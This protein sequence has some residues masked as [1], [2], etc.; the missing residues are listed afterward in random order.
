MSEEFAEWKPAISGKRP[1]KSGHRCHDTERADKPDCGD[2]TLHGSGCSGGPGRLVEDL[3]N[4]VARGCLQ[5]CLV[6]SDAEQEDK[7][8]GEC[9]RAV[10]GD[11]LNQHPRNHD[12]CV[13]Y[14]FAHM[15]SS[16]EA[17]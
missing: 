17:W 3:N 5:R 8:E 15:D 1:G 9:Q 4:G 13:P 10:N 14:L 12:G 16:I 2:R 7:H 6:V 11:R